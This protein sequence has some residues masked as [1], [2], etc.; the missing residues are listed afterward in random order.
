M[1]LITELLKQS[2]MH[3][4]NKALQ[5][6]TQDRYHS[7]WSVLEPVALL[8]P[9]YSHQLVESLVYIHADLCRRLHVRHLQLPGKLLTLLLSHL[10]EKVMDEGKKRKR[11]MRRREGRGARRSREG[12]GRGI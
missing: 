11:M 4:E 8:S 1:M 12:R 6:P 10:Y 2:I 9:Y 3:S 7:L 5:S